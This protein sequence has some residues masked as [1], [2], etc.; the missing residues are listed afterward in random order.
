ME[1]HQSFAECAVV[2]CGTLI[3]E[4]GQLRKEG[5]LDA[6]RVL[7]TKPGRHE[8]PRELEA[9]LVERVGLA[10]Q[11]ADRIIVVYGGTFC[12]VNVQDPMRSLDRVLSELGPGIA[13]VQASHCVDMLASA[14]ERTMFSA[15]KKVLWLTPGWIRFRNYVYQ[16]WDKGKA[17]E[18]FPQHTGGAVLLDGIGFWEEYSMTHPE[19]ILDFSD[20]MGIP[21]TVHPVSL[22]RL[23]TLL[24]V[25][26]SG[27]PA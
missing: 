11:T 25:C 21:I 6:R 8:V 23:K 16:D 17:N 4:L 22:D 10:R 20:W 12:Y 24:A 19:E 3:P 14:E 27:Q 2:S 15:G 9:Q 18:N 26:V 1:E 7:F 13:R 5:F